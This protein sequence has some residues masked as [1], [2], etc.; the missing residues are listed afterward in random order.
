MGIAGRMLEIA[1]DWSYALS[2][3]KSLT[4]SGV[5][6]DASGDETAPLARASKLIGERKLVPDDT[7]ELLQP[8]GP[9]TQFL[10]ESRQ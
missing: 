2:F 9:T 1:P 7:A 10:S 3:C 6:A 8:R 5:D 4:E